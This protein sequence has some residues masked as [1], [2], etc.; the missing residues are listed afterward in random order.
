MR[1][2]CPPFT[3]CWCEQHPGHPRCPEALPIYN[4]LFSICSILLIIYLAYNELK[5]KK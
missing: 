1:P 3:D 2:P 5:N 4:P